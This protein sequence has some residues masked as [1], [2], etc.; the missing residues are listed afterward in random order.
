MNE[1]GSFKYDF[2]VKSGAE[3]N[4]IRMEIKGFKNFSTDNDELRFSLSTGNLVEHI[5]LSW[6]SE[7]GE[8]VQV[9]YK[10]IERTE[11]KIV[12]GFEMEKPM[13]S[14]H[15]LIVDPEPVLDWGF[16]IGD[17]LNSTGNDVITDVD[18]LIYS[19]GTTSSLDY[20]A[21]TGAF[22][23][24]INGNSDAY[25]LK[26]YTTGV[27][28]WATYF[29]GSELETGASI[30]ID[31]SRNIFLTGITE[32]SDLVVTDSL[33]PD[34]LKGDKDIYIAKFS[35]DGDYFWSRY[36]GTE[37][38]EED[39]KI[40]CDFTGNFY[41]TGTT[42]SDTISTTG[43]YQENIAG[44]KDAFV[45]KF[46]SEGNII[47]STYLGGS[48]EDVATSVETSDSLL[49]ITGYSS[50]G[51]LGTLGVHQEVKNDSVD[52][53][54]AQLDTSGQLQWFTYFG[55][56]KEDV[57]TGLKVLNNVIAF[58]GY[59]KSDSSIIYGT[60]IHQDIR[61]GGYD[62][63]VGRLLENGTVDWSSYFGGSSDDFGVDLSIEF[64]Q[65]IILAGNTESLDSISTTDV[66]QVNNNGAFDI[67]LSKFTPD[68]EQIWGSFYGGPE[69][70][71]CKSV[72][73]Y[74]NT[75]IYVTGHTFSDTNMVD[76]LT[77]APYGEYSFQKDALLSKFTQDKSTECN[78]G[79]CSGADGSGKPNDPYT[80]CRG[81]EILLTTNGGATGSNAQWVWYENGCGSSGQ[82]VGVGDTI[83]LTPDVSTVY[84]VRAESG[85][86]ATDCSSIYVEV[87]ETPTVEILS[88]GVFCNESTYTI[89]ANA[90]YD[91]YWTFPNDSI[92]YDLNPI[93]TDISYQDTGWYTLSSTA[94]SSG[95]TVH[96]SLFLSP[97]DS[98]IYTLDIDSI[99]CY[100]YN[101]GSIEILTDDTTYL[102]SWVPGGASSSL[103]SD[104]DS[105][106]YVVYITDTNSCVASDSIH[107]EGKDPYILDA[108][109]T[110]TG[111]EFDNGTIEL[112]LDTVQ[113]P[114]DISW[115]HSTDN[116]PFIDSL[117]Y[118][119]YLAT[120]IKPDGCLDTINVEVENDNGLAIGFT[121]VS[122][123][124]C[125]N[126]NDAS[127]T[128]SAT[129]GDG[130]TSFSWTHDP[131]ITDSMVNGLSPGLYEVI[132]TDTMGCSAYDTITLNPAPELTWTTNM[133]ETDCGSATGQISVLVSNQ[134]FFESIQWSHSGEQFLELFDLP[135]GLYSFE[136]IDTNGCSY[137]DNIQLTSLDNY[138]VNVTPSY[139]L[140]NAGEEVT[141][142]ASTSTGVA[143]NTYSW[144]PDSFINCTNCPITTVYPISTTDYIVSVTHNSG[145]SGQDTA[146]VVIENE[147]VEVF[148]PDHF[149]PNNDGLNDDWC[150]I[151]SCIES[152]R[153]QVYNRWGE[154]VFSN[155]SPGNCWDGTLNGE[156]VQNGSYV[157]DIDVK[158]LSGESIER[159]GSV[160]VVR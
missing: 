117:G 58:S 74:G 110:P 105:G 143:N 160:K 41:L 53:F 149:S 96:D 5:P 111:C 121:T 28:L 79:S 75:S 152:A 20:I 129:G 142:T 33:F 7:S 56:E 22:Q 81:D 17:S 145:C 153:V 35:E 12:V 25:L 4:S 91:Y 13:M 83:S 102:Y 72:D 119:N 136:L 126:Q 15:T 104:L 115:V 70:D 29:G 23:D 146:R 47:W 49:Y 62:A 139:T 54:I 140:V 36:F 103:I 94:S 44:A 151:G 61:H 155:D 51:G 150:I 63:F 95:C 69:N 48:E 37:G 137:S 30:A 34:T 133:Q 26:A 76:T 141:L 45:T 92:V 78:G 138:E 6:Y 114:F 90:D 11:S 100:G 123:E 42:N 18:G 9:N 109:S 2:I 57:V 40:D 65:N 106:M 55:G 21:T 156:L 52:G 84:F 87:L 101:D 157:F 159:K 24:T 89:Q 124:S 14:G 38:S 127:L 132:V 147:C 113:G 10:I 3:L 59:T 93:I 97:S 85:T 107:L 46:S 71:I 66:H 68:G 99:S 112:I 120:V 67:F 116:T 86:D 158:L 130:E 98:I 118:G 88:N 134:S 148:I 73:V 144:S 32:S 43:A 128:A 39:P 8:E 80:I 31:T 27:V 50:S 60:E 154:M 16:Y 125:P 1:K 122:P 82:Q 19:T 64:D 131:S 135:A 77:A 108:I